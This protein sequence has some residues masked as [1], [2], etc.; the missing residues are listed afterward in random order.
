ME[1]RIIRDGRDPARVVGGQVTAELEALEIGKPAE[2][3][4]DEDAASASWGFGLKTALQIGSSQSYS[5]SPS[6]T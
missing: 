2:D 6:R 4:Y 5:P 1:E 3:W